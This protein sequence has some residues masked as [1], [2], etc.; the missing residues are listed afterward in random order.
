MPYKFIEH[1]ADLKIQVD[2]PT[3]EKAFMTSAFA[4]REAIAE[5]IKVK[6][7][8]SRIISVEGKD[9][10]DLLYKFLEEFL[11]LLDAQDFLL[12]YFEDLEIVE[13]KKEK[14]FSL[15]AKVLGDKA[16]DYDFSNNVKAITFNEMDIFE[17]KNRGKVF[18]QFVLDV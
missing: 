17:N 14:K 10:Y 18:I 16:S 11:F 6:P 13:H 15:S 7:I 9:L 5:K 2:E 12:S 8:S 4:M 3:L 1:T